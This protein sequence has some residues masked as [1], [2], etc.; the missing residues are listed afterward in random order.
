MHEAIVV[1]LYVNETL[2]LSIK[3]SEDSNTP[4]TVSRW[5]GLRG[6]AVTVAAVAARVLPAVASPPGHGLRVGVRLR[7]AGEGPALARGL[8][9]P[10][11]L[12]AHALGRSRILVMVVLRRSAYANLQS[13]QLGTSTWEER[14]Q[15]S[16]SI[17]MSDAQDLQQLLLLLRGLIRVKAVRLVDHD[18]R[19]LVAHH[20]AAEA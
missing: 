19:A 17:R 8:H 2:L 10:Q 12:Q 13:T 11:D 6:V 5:R 15:T 9:V 7:G 20:G 16:A 14:S 18:R 1:R 3:I 4:S